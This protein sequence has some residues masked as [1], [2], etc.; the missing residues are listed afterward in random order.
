MLSIN[1]KARLKNKTFWISI[2][3]A[4]L[5]L[6]QQLGFN[7]T[8]VIPGNYVEIINTIFV[9]LTMLGI[10][11]DTSTSGVSDQIISNNLVEQESS[12]RDNKENSEILE[13]SREIDNNILS[14][15]QEQTMDT[16]EGSIISTESKEPELL[17]NKSNVMDIDSSSIIDNKTTILSTS[18]DSKAS[19]DNTENS[20][21]N[22]FKSNSVNIGKIN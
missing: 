17:T 22:D 12:I 9:I 14:N 21:L 20:A 8:K 3:S 1:L 10:T 18:A 11:V 6:L 16:K 13:V 15:N 7:A 4:V 19:I 2:I 5:L